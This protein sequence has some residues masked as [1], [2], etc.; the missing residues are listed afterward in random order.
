M[1]LVFPAYPQDL[2]TFN[3]TKAEFSSY[4]LHLQDSTFGYECHSLAES[5]LLRNF[6]LPISDYI[7]NKTCNK[8][9]SKLPAALDA[10]MEKQH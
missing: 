2:L 1:D 5:A 7:K 10:I 8:R 3:N 9:Q 6:N 4:E